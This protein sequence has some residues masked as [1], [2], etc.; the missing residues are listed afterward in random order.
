MSTIVNFELLYLDEK[1]KSAELKT[2]RDELLEAL[3]ESMTGAEIGGD[4]GAMIRMH[5]ALINKI[6][7]SE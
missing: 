2:Q 5:K 7:A 6:E 1:R 4:A 3:K